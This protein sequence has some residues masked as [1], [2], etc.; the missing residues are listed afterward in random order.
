MVHTQIDEEN[1]QNKLSNFHHRLEIEIKLKPDSI[2]ED[3][4]GQ[5]QTEE[6]PGFSSVMVNLCIRPFAE[7]FLKFILDLPD[8]FTVI[9]TA[10]PYEYAAKILP[11][12]LPTEKTACSGDSRLLNSRSD[13]SSK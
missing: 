3:A 4:A 2:D 1:G 9:Y 6:N 8:I 5:E 12:L 13:G 11:L 7:Q 10:S